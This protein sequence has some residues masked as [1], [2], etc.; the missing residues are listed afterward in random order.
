MIVILEV[1][2]MRPSAPGLVV[3]PVGCGE[4]E[5]GGVEGVV[6]AERDRMEE[7]LRM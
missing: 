7:D 4:A 1:A 2:T 6:S 5:R 3:V